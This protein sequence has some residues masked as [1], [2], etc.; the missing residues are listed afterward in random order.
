MQT[1]CTPTPACAPSRSLQSWSYRFW[2]GFY[3][4]GTLWHPPALPAVLPL[5][6]VT[7][8]SPV[9]MLH[10]WPSVRLDSKCCKSE[11]KGHGHL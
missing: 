6:A 5:L 11:V 1:P 10:P 2:Q 8:V 7:V 3:I 9:M 4:P